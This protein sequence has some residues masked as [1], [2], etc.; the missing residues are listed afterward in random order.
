MRELFGSWGTL[1][2]DSE[3]ALALLGLGLIPKT[4]RDRGVEVALAAL[5][6]RLS[7]PPIRP[8]HWVLNEL[9]ADRNSWANAIPAEKLAAVCR[10]QLGYWQRIEVNTRGSFDGLQLWELWHPIISGSSA[11]FLDWNPGSLYFRKTGRSRG[12]HFQWPS[13]VGYF[14]GTD[15]EDSALELQQSD[16]W[17]GN[18]FEVH[19]LSRRNVRCDILTLTGENSLGDLFD[20]LST[21]SMA[22]GG[23]SADLVVV[24]LS[25]FELIRRLD[26]LEPLRRWV[27]ALG[28][29]VLPAG[30]DF[31]SIAQS[32]RNI[33]I[34]LS[35]NQPLDRAVAVATGGN[36]L[37]VADSRLI[38]ISQLETRVKVSAAALEL[39]GD[40]D[41][42]V[43]IGSE[44]AHRLGIDTEAPT[45]RDLGV[46]LT[47]NVDDFGWLSEGAEASDVARVLRRIEQE[48][49]T[50]ARYLQVGIL[51]SSGRRVPIA[52]PL[53]PQREYRVSVL[54]GIE[55]GGYLRG[56]EIFPDG[57]LPDDGRSHLLTV[58]FWDHWV[59]AKPRIKYL[60][61]P[62][63]GNCKPCEFNIHTAVS[64]KHLK[65]RITVL[66]RNRVLQSGVLGAPVG[67]QAGHFTFTLD[68]A[69]RTLLSRLDERL[70][71][72][73]AFVLNDIDGQSYI[74]TMR[75][76]QAAVLDMDDANVKALQ[77]TLSIAI[78]KITEDPTNYQGLNA[79]GTETLL[80]VL[81]QKGASLREY[82]MRYA[83]RGGPIAAPAYVQLVAA[84]PEK[85]LPLEF[86]YEFEAPDDDAKL[87]VNAEKA[88]EAIP[89]LSDM[90]ELAD[91]RCD[92][93][94]IGSPGYDPAKII[95]PL[96]FWGLRCVIERR[97]MIPDE[98]D[99]A[100]GETW[101]ITEPVDADARLLHPLSSA[102]VGATK[103]ASQ[104]DVQAVDKM[105]ERIERLVPTVDVVHSWEAWVDAV[106]KT[107]YPTLLTLLVHQEMDDFGPQ[108][109]IGSKPYLK[110][111]LIKNKHV[112]PDPTGV[113]PLALLIGCETARADIDYENAALRFKWRGA[114]VVVS[115]IAKVLGREAAPVAAELI[116]EISRATEPTSFGI[117]MRNLRRRLL[118]TGTPMVLSLTALGDA[119]WDV[120]GKS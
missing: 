108:L 86:L 81:A 1:L 90:N 96:A 52:E 47:R 8:L 70:N 36:A 116:E 68:L 89:I 99:R 7:K 26:D 74:H 62:P 57:M 18:V 12:I 4:R 71:F 110:T 55:D 41:A 109:D 106:K 76:G 15:G 104:F 102:V 67:E 10:E 37:L 5:A 66:H 27:G 45:R 50:P 112:R 40:R 20:T 22:L 21:H 80:R 78:T 84:K 117:I 24:S 72:D 95:C 35:H 44:V 32:L 11:D 25:D 46:A 118:L 2:T 61:L 115:T 73:A 94:P 39:T 38:A 101:L 17:D 75:G 58:V 65:A 6:K 77:D 105:I 3:F 100:V 9:P 19:P 48:E 93:C 92:A 54:I 49:K 53:T 51:S 31:V 69:P 59:A 103:K 16:A 83:L 56:E 33:L 43:N 34:E 23:V 107:P 88:L 87:C 82:L 63:T 98:R 120:V 85:I 29:I 28:L 14:P 64:G 60:N 13:Q 42:T 79:P 111:E 119:D 91:Q 113:M 114:A 97:E 30:V